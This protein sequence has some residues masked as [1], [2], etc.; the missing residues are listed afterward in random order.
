MRVLWGLRARPGDQ[1]PAPAPLGC[2]GDQDRP[3]SVRRLVSVQSSLSG[4]RIPAAPHLRSLPDLM[5]SLRLFPVLMY[6]LRF[7]IVLPGFS[8]C[9]SWGTEHRVQ[10]LILLLLLSLTD[11]PILVRSFALITQAES[12]QE[13]G[14]ASSFRPSPM[15]EVSKEKSKQARK[16]LGKEGRKEEAMNKRMELMTR[17]RRKK[18]AKYHGDSLGNGL[19]A[20]G[21]CDM[22][23]CCPCCR[24][25]Q[26]LG[27]FL[28]CA[29]PKHI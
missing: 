4:V 6:S 10:L 26:S 7:T 28:L 15:K 23:C 8:L 2:V 17:D 20:L 18:W 27:L 13:T 3:G 24:Q 19:F 12:I 21:R 14:H 5:Y 16:R 22:G 29:P 9:V 1:R 25:R 11:P